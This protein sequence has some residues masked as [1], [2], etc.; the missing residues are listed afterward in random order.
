[1][2]SY[3]PHYFLATCFIN[4]RKD[5]GKNRAKKAKGSGSRDWHHV[6]IDN[7]PHDRFCN[8]QVH[9]QDSESD[10]DSDSDRS[11]ASSQVEQV[12]KSRKQSKRK[13]R[14]HTVRCKFWFLYRVTSLINVLVGPDYRVSIKKEG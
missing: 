4:F 3:T 7:S 1:M 13:R 5:K 8:L 14:K 6:V 12:H 10:S 9:M 2:V 11:S